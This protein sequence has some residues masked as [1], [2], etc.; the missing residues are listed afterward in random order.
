MT[1]REYK[2]SRTYQESP[3]R[4]NK[5]TRKIRLSVLQYKPMEIMKYVVDEQVEL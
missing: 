2:I 4:E 3:P 1:K 5:V